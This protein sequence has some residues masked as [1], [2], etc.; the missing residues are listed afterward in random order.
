MTRKICGGR[1]PHGRVGM[2]RKNKRDILMTVDKLSQDFQIPSHN[3]AEAFPSM[4]RQ[5]N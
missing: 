3:L 1:F 5:D 2:N 4:G